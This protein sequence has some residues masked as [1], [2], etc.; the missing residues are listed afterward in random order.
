MASQ[1]LTDAKVYAGQYDWSG[2]MNSIALEYA[3]EMKDC[4]V[5]GTTTR[6]YKGGLKTVRLGTSGFWSAGTDEIDSEIFDRV[7]AT[8]VPISITPGT[9]AAGQ[10]CYLFRATRAD[11]RPGA[12]VGE[13]F[14]FQSSAI[15]SA[16]G[17][18]AR[19]TMLFNGTASSTS[20]GTKYQVGAITATQKAYAALHVFSVSGTS[21]TCTVAIQSDAD[22]SAG[23]E[24]SRITFTQATAATSEWKELSGAITDQWWRVS[25]TIGGTSPSFTF[26]VTFGII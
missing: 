4:T 10:A 5:F 14:A 9:G 8:A 16:G 12:P 24:T 26:A 17:R 3:A 11:Y 23:S 18:L 25:Y 7:G 19:G 21:P 15:A 13:M 6:Q 1:I 2:D 20:T 22:S